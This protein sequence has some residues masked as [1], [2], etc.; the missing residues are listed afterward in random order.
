MFGLMLRIFL[1]GLVIYILLGLVMG[2]YAHIC[3]YYFWMR[4]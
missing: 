3:H 4:P 1:I 2:W